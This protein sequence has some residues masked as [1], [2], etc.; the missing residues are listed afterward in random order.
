MN[1]M[2]GEILVKVTDLEDFT[3]KTVRFRVEPMYIR[4]QFDII[5]L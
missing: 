2:T 5:L 3:G 4:E 1:R